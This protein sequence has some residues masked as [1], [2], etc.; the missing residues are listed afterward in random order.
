MIS[1]NKLEEGLYLP[2]IFESQKFNNIQ[3]LKIEKLDNQYFV[4]IAQF[5]K[6]YQNNKILFFNTVKEMI[7]R[8]GY[9]ELS[10]TNKV[11][12]IITNYFYDDVIHPIYIFDELLSEKGID[13][14]EVFKVQILLKNMEINNFKDLKGIPLEGFKYLGLKESDM[15]LLK[16]IFKDNGCGLKS[17]NT[18]T[19]EEIHSEGEKQLYININDVKFNKNWD[20]ELLEKYEIENFLNIKIDLG[21]QKISVNKYLKKLRG[22]SEIITKDLK[23]SIFFEKI[24]KTKDLNEF[25]DAINVKLKDN[26]KDILRWR[27]AGNTLQDIANILGVTRERVR[28][29]S[30]KS[31]EI[32]RDRLIEIGFFQFLENS[33]LYL[34]ENTVLKYVLTNIECDGIF[35]D[36]DLEIFYNKNT[37]KMMDSLKSIINYVSNNQITSISLLKKEISNTFHLDNFNI[38]KYLENMDLKVRE[39]YIIK[40]PLKK[41]E[42]YR[43]VIKNFYKDTALDLS[44]EEGYND[45]KNKVEKI[46]IDPEEIELK[47]YSKKDIRRITAGIERLGSEILKLGSD[48]YIHF[49]FSSLP[50]DVLSK[51]EKD[52]RTEI[53]FNGFVSVK[54]LYYKYKKELE[55][56]SIHEDTLYYIL[57][58]LLDGEFYFYGKSST[59]RIFETEDYF[60]STEELI[61]SILEQNDNSMNIDDLIDLMGV[62]RYTIDAAI[63]NNSMFLKN[64][65]VILFE[66]DKSDEIKEALKIIEDKF[67]KLL[68]DEEYVSISNMYNEFQLDEELNKALIILNCTS[69]KM[70]R[71]FLSSAV[72]CHIG[73]NKVVF[74]NPNKFGLLDLLFKEKG[75]GNELYRKDIID[76]LHE[77][78]YKEPTIFMRLREW[79]EEFKLVPINY[80]R[81]AREEGIVIDCNL[82]HE[83][84][85]FLEKYIN[86]DYVSVSKLSEKFAELPY[87]PV[88]IW[89][90]DFFAYILKRYFN[91]KQVD[92]FTFNYDVDPFIMV[93]GNSET[94]YRQI[95]QNEMKNF[96][97]YPNEKNV[98][99]Y[100]KS[101]GLIPESAKVIYIE[102]YNK[103]IF[104]KD[105]IGKVSTS[106]DR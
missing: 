65:E 45:F 93:N 88:S 8:G 98:L 58:L 48:K 84:K 34:H 83:I 12:N 11:N 72:D 17:F 59:F 6:L 20:K 70:F 104:T 44:S 76:Y 102:L 22:Y 96:K 28:Q 68:Q 90:N 39:N 55:H 51:I 82:I 101:L 21:D 40:Y 27:C 35:F 95:I 9:F 99:K 60:K 2:S 47:E 25:V 66:E 1:G 13:D 7:F 67:Y 24:M 43:Y 62:E 5:R 61:I 4:D 32:I 63:Q 105:E 37:E 46:D 54:K 69:L 92:D 94:N 15:P 36:S 80:D 14:L 18:E 31:L 16:K 33:K 41:I 79:L 64:N 97:D 57:H 71:N 77:I 103:N 26:R 85:K 78:T 30:K 81:Y 106:Y 42:V 19:N 89:S 73:N 52:L 38:K 49:E 74:K 29:I 23:Q 87:S 10:D 100:L 75:K 91:Y 56:Y 3:N 86:K 50:I 53:D